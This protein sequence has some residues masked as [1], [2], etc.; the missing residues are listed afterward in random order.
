MTLPFTWAFTVGTSRIR[1]GKA[2]PKCLLGKMMGKDNTGIV[3]MMYP[4]ISKR[5]SKAPVIIST[6]TRYRKS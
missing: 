2:I 1:E 4:H 5:R 6:I 3:D